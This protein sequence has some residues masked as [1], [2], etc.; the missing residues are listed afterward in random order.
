LAFE[1]NQGQAA[2]QVN[3]LAHGSGYTVSLT[4][5]DAQISLSQGTTCNT[6]DL[7]LLDANPSAHVVGQN[8]L[9]TK[10]NYLLGSDPRQWHTNI[11]NYG[12]VEYQNVYRGVDALYSGNQGQLETTFV[13]HPG[14]SPGVIQM[15]V[16]GAQGLSL[17][18]QGNLVLHTTGGDV[19]EQAPIAYQEI[20]G[21]RQSVSSRYV[22]EG[23]N[24]IGFQVGTYDP[25]Q[26]LV[27]DPTL[28]Y[29]S[30]LPGPGVA[31]AV[32]S[33]GDAY[34]TGHTTGSNDN[35]LIGNGVF[36]DKLNASGTAL[37][38]QTFLSGSGG[39][40]AIA[41]DAEGDAYVAG[42]AGTDLPTT[43]N[44]L[45][46]TDPSTAI[47]AFLS[48]LDPSGSGLLYSTWL[49][50]TTGLPSSPG[51][52]RIVSPSL[53]I[54]PAS[55]G[56]LDN[57]YLTGAAA[58]GFPTTAGAYQPNYA[59]GTS[60]RDAFFAQI[61]P[62]QSGSASLLYGSYLGAGQDGGTGITV[63]SSGNAYLVGRT[64]STNFPTTAGAFQ[65]GNGGGLDTFVAKFNPSQ[66]GTASLAYSTYLGGS[67]ADGFSPWDVPTAYLDNQQPGPSIAVDST[68][69]AY[70]AGMTTSTNFPTTAGAFQTQYGGDNGVYRGDGFVTKL[71]ATGTGL[72][73]STFLGGSGQDGATSIAVDAS[74]DADVAGMTRS[75]NFPTVNPIQAHKSSDPKKGFPNA[76]TF[77]ATLNPSGSGLL[78]S[79]YLGGTGGDDYAYGLALDSAGNVY[80]TGQTYSSSFPTTAGALQT[81]P[82]GGFVYKID[83]PVGAAPISLAT[84]SA[85]SGTVAND[86][87]GTASAV[88]FGGTASDAVAVKIPSA[89]APAS[90]GESG[91]LLADSIFLQT[92]GPSNSEAPHEE[93]LTLALPGQRFDSLLSMGAGERTI[94]LSKPGRIRVPFVADPSSPDDV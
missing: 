85:A 6:L 71:N 91:P 42:Y 77:V 90:T 84:T 62:N 45:Q 19:M 21:V 87:A 49:P 22:L 37:L 8:E 52:L 47:T 65:R 32:D 41:V 51:G 92:G 40:N 27:I 35:S 34:I 20:N 24:T 23:D 30:Y 64:Y 55:D 93:S 76:D 4:A 18:A 59:G 53:A 26:T 36:V 25:S 78:F 28:S 13:V 83:P 50:G 82:G 57:V 3:Y 75:T 73:Y 80:V 61:D 66:S 7:R 12:E 74:G 89:D 31:I 94:G 16:Q 63:D 33:S 56:S 1:V 9:I 46:P 69:S 60:G 29:S 54:A 67:G 79:T 72:V 15:Q 81:T 68:G 17:D 44:A 5:Q 10:T 48:V 38:Y 70:V 39:G 58:A 11:A 88:R 86:A 14:A 2:P 43:P